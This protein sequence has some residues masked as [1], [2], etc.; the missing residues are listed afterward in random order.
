MSESACV[1]ETLIGS[2]EACDAQCVPVPITSCFNDDSCC[3]AGCDPSTDN[4]CSDSCG[5]GV[6]DENETCDP[7]AVGGCPS[8]CD[9]VDLCTNDTL[10]GTAEACNAECVFAPIIECSLETDGCCAPGCNSLDDG[11]CSSSCGNGV[12]EGDELCDGDCSPVCP[13]PTS[14]CEEAVLSGTSET[15]DLSCSLEPIA[16]CISDDGCCAPGCDANSD[17]DCSPIC[18]NGVLEGGELCDGD[19]PIACEAP[20]ACAEAL[21]TGSSETCD[22][23]CSFVAIDVCASGDGCCAPDCDANSDSD[24]SA[25][26]GNGSIEDG[27]TCDGEDCPS[28]CDDGLACTT[29]VLVGAAESCSAACVFN[30]VTECLAV[31]DGCCAPGCNSGN[32]PDCS[33]ACGNGFKDEGETCDGEDCNIV[34][35]DGVACTADTTIGSAETCNVACSY[36]EIEVCVSDDGCCPA[37]CNVVSDSD[38]SASCGDG[39]VSDDETCDPG[40]EDS[41][42]ESCND[43]NACTNDSLSGAAESCSL[44]CSYTEVLECISDD[45]CCAPG[46]NSLNDNDCSPEC[47]NGVIEAGEACDGDC[48]TTCS[49]D[50]AC[51]SVT[52]T[53]AAETC[54]AVCVAE[55]ILACVDD[56]GCCG[57]GQDDSGDALCSLANDNDCSATCGDGVVSDGKPVIPHWMIAARLLAMIATCVRPIHW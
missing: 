30:P 12:V 56:D 16:A 9:D 53:G 3:A 57:L 43:N 25:S 32:D 54:D 40:L 35:D 2:A 20:S 1:P 5:D 21:L 45:G 23:Q 31:S 38:C 15:C 7:L 13:E 49:S 36:A 47:G 22:A 44:D 29:D 17:A 6:L 4:D 50:N 34:C 55:A 42:P 52:L 28:S 24:C 33:A 26:C 18:G 41:C 19:C 11:D 48:P 10:I 51:E 8:S 39:V 46:C 37:G 27:E 14:A